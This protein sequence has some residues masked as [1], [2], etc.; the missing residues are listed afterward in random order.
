MLFSP[1]LVEFGVCIGLESN[2][3]PVRAFKVMAFISAQ[4]GG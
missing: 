4:V 3:Q 1:P 2:P